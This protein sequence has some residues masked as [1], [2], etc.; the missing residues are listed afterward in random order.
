VQY[1]EFQ[2]EGDLGGTY[3]ITV[4]AQVEGYTVSQTTSAIAMTASEGDI[5]TSLEALNNT[6]GIEINIVECDTINCRY[7]LTF[8]NMDANVPSITIDDNMIT[9]NSMIHRVTTILHGRDASDIIDSPFTMFTSPDTTNA[10]YTTAYG[11]GLVYGVTGTT[12]K[13]TIQSKDAWGNN[14]LDSQDRDIYKVVA[15]IAD[16]DFDD[17]RIAVDGTVMYSGDADFG[18]KYDVEYTPVI[19]GEYTVSVMLGE[20]VEVQNISTTWSSLSQ[21]SG[22]FT[23][24]YGIC[25]LVKPCPVTKRLSWDSTGDVIEKALEEL[26]GVGDV[27]VTFSQTT[28]LMNSAWLVTFNTAC[29]MLEIFVHEGTV[30]INIVTIEQGTCSIIKAAEEL[31]FC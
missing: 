26:A 21:R 29:D 17:D 2:S 28:D 22:Y 3:T 31:A 30:P 5:T 24:S 27:T 1:I 15:F 13:F 18:G 10:A 6:E 23:L 11:Q 20:Q 14:K 8:L 9:G 7:T 12:S 25:T 16:R 19:S 4:T